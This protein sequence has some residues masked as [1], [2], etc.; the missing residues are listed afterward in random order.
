MVTEVYCHQL[1]YLLS[2]VYST[3][4]HCIHTLGNVQGIYIHIAQKKIT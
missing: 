1:G 3:K 2:E 4:L